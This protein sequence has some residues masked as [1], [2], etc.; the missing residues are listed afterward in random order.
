[1]TWLRNFNLR[2]CL[3]YKSEQAT[4]NCIHIKLKCLR[5]LLHQVFLSFKNCQMKKNYRNIRWEND[6]SQRIWCSRSPSIWGEI[7]SKINILNSVWTKHRAKRNLSSCLSNAAFQSRDEWRSWTRSSVAIRRL[8][9]AGR[10][11]QA[12]DFAIDQLCR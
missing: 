3:S 8:S 7:N 11:L 6:A 9:G 5:G 12:S 1:M 10:E 4:L 2:K